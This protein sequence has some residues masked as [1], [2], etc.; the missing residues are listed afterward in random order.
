[1]LGDGEDPNKFRRNPGSNK[2]FLTMVGG[3][4]FG[5]KSQWITEA[6]ARCLW[7]YRDCGLE[8][9]MVCFRGVEPEI[10][11]LVQ[12]AKTELLVG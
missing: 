4:V 3:G 10:K 5:N 11:K 12:R 1:M 6:I 2:L 9:V 7:T 8:V